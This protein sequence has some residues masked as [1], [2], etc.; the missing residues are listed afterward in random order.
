MYARLSVVSMGPGMRPKMEQLADHL[1][2]RFKALKGY[3]G[4]TFL[5]DEASGD[6]GSLSLW[7]SREHAEAASAAINPQVARIFQGMLTPWIFE[8]YEPKT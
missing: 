6:Y 8:V 7:D 2:P 1:A 5:M 3:R 4:V